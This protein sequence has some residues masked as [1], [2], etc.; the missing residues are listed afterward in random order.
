MLE[1]IFVD[2]Y[3]PAKFPMFCNNLKSLSTKY[4]LWKKEE[5]GYRLCYANH[6]AP[7]RIIDDKII[8]SYVNDKDDGYGNIVNTGV[9]QYVTKEGYIVYCIDYFFRKK[10]DRFPKDSFEFWIKT[11]R[12]EEDGEDRLCC[13]TET[14]RFILYGKYKYIPLNKRIEVSLK[15]G[16]IDM[17][18]YEE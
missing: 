6:M 1:N 12:N 10:E 4:S 17:W 8:F 3:N 15:D 5:E 2:T 14:N 11:K 9:S 16:S 7:V 13:C 18:T